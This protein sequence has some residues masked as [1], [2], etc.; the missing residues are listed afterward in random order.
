VV[1]IVT[2][3]EARTALR[4]ADVIDAIEEAHRAL[5]EG[6]AFQP[7]RPVV[8]IPGSSAVMIPMAAASGPHQAVGLKVMTDAPDNPAYGRP[9]Q[10]SVIVLFDPVTGACEAVL[11]GGAITQVR[12]AAA[13]AVA[14]KHLANAEGTT[15]GLVGAGALARAH[16]RAIRLVRPVTRVVVWSRSEST[17]ERFL[18]DARGQGVDV[19]VARTPREVVEAADVLCT[20]TPSPQPIVLGDW[21]R[22]GMHVNVVGAPPRP[23]YQEID[24]DAV[25]RCQLVVDDAGVAMAE[26]GV[27]AAALADG[28]LPPGPLTELG[29]VLTGAK[30]GRRSAQQITMYLSVGVGIQDV[31]TARLVVDVA[32]ELGL[33][34]DA[35]LTA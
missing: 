15:L 30:K 25:T 6:R 4:M 19:V 7:G 9:R 24:T 8:P 14:T 18:D 27:L 35:D 22:E 34:V 13:S 29:E 32:R 2:R 1:L 33:G 3:S 26:S 17:T 23:S 10:Q 21:L 5:A 20:L 31:V 16:L 12:T 28:A 11:D